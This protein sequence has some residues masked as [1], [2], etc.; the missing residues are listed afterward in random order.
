MAIG[1]PGPDPE[2][3]RKKS[4]PIPRKT[5]KATKPLR[6]PAVRRR[7]LFCCSKRLVASYV[8]RMLRSTFGTSR[9]AG[10]VI[11]Y[12]STGWNLNIWAIRLS[13]KT[14]CAVL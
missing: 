4:A 13:G 10:S 1:N 11:W 14:F 12:S 9:S 6:M 2:P 3:Y 8:G 7:F 5:R